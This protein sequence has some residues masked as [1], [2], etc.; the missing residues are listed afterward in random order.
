MT[1]SFSMCLAVGVQ[2]LG[3]TGLTRFQAASTLS[4]SEHHITLVMKTA[5]FFISS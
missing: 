2:N 4:F 3:L 1:Q 5:A